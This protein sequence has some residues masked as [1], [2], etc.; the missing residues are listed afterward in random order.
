MAD[1][2]NHPE[3]YERNRFTCEPKDLTKYLPHPLASAVE[4]IL[5]APYKGTEETDLKKAVWWLKELLN[6]PALWLGDRVICLLDV[7]DSRSLAWLD[8]R[9]AMGAMCMKNRYVEN[10]FFE[11]GQG[12]CLPNRETVINTIAMI[13]I[14]GAEQ[15]EEEK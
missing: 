15:D 8:V 5:R 14:E 2:I 3:H 9:V 12:V 10:L 7:M 4:Y 13:E 1:L 11:R 6:T